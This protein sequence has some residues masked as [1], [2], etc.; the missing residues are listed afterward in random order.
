MDIRDSIRAGL[1]Q[2]DF[3]VQGYLSDLSQAELLARPCAGGNHIAWQLGHL[4]A[5]ERHFGEKAS[6]NS[7]PAL[8]AGFVERHK[9]EHAASNDASQFNS[10]AEYL[11]LMKEQ[12]EGYLKVVASLPDAR[13]DEAIGGGL[14][15][16]LKN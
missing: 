16:F 9:K 1:R 3:I 10:K 8:P 13:F 14:P 15:P 12:R 7:M 5:S 6:P 11:R 2:S 4:I